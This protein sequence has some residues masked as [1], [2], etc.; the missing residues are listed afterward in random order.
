M[1]K[2]IHPTY[3]SN[4][5]DIPASPAFNVTSGTQSDGSP[6][7]LILNSA[8][9]KCP[10][11]SDEWITATVE[12]VKT[13]A[14]RGD[15]I[16]TGTAPLQWDF[17]SF[18][19]GLYGARVR[20]IV[21]GCNDEKGR[22]DYER[23][24][25]DLGLARERTEAAFLGQVN[26]QRP[27]AVWPARDKL[28]TT[29]ADTIYP[30][31]IH[32]GGKLDSLLTECTT[33]PKIDNTFRTVWRQGKTERS[34]P[35]GKIRTAASLFLGEWLVHWTRSC[36]GPWPGED[37]RTY[38]TDMLS[39]PEIYVRNAKETLLRIVGEKMIRGSGW[40]MAGNRPVV[41][42]SALTPSEA[43]AL[44][45]WRKRYVRESFE[46]YGIAVRKNRL[47]E[48][49]AGPVVYVG[50]GKEALSRDRLFL[51]SSG[52]R[53]DWEKES[54]WRFPGNVT[55]SHFRP[56]DITLIVPDSIT[57]DEVMRRSGCVYAV[58]E[59]FDT[60]KRGK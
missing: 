58:H 39:R 55:L 25:R 46:P 56:E 1:G 57:A 4:E 37:A 26:R 8:Q 30:V 31:S 42:F 32:P 23:L 53:G 27:K 2:K 36:H 35:S 22:K 50:K 12:A 14:H 9:S 10:K 45:R 13:C 7:V 48:A 49:G 19:A 38:F 17:V 33:L 15:T 20:F 60:G 59:L 51:Q 3:N 21:N 5:L 29:L 24:I 52:T 34:R 54:E 18:L 43:L 44:M 40:R 47:V 11:G 16:I 6:H 28:S 41:S